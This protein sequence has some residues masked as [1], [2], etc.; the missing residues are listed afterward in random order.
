MD[1]PTRGIDAA[2]WRLVCVVAVATA[3]LGVFLTWLGDGPVRVAGTQGSNNG[4]LALILA[5]LALVWLRW[6]ERGSWIG[7]VGMLGSGLVIGWTALE[8][9]LDAR[10]TFGAS[11]GV[12]LLLVLAAG[13]VLATVAVVRGAE[14]ARGELRHRSTQRV[15]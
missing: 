3:A 6:L 15:A 7:V 5:L 11:V 2:T 8:N 4:W 1:G 9:W 10:A 12:G 13:A 14:L